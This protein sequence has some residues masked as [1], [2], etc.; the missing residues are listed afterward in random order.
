MLIN[1]ICRAA[2]GFLK[3]SPYRVFSRKKKFS[4]WV[5]AAKHVCFAFSEKSEVFVGNKLSVESGTMIAAREGSRLFCLCQSQ[6]CH[7]CKRK[8]HS[9]Q[10][11]YNRPQLL[12]L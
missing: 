6:L 5:L 4:G 12:Y 9:R 1:K 7:C 3:T 10:W 11:C 8:N 2:R